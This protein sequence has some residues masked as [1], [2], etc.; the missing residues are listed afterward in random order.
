MTRP[1]ETARENG[2]KR[3]IRVLKQKSPLKSEV[4]VLGIL[5]Q[6][7]KQN[8]Q[9]GK[10]IMEKQ[11]KGH[12]HRGGRPSKL[13]K[14]LLETICEYLIQW[15]YLAEAIQKAGISR[16]S[17][18]RYMKIK[19]FARA[20]EEAQERYHEKAKE[21]FSDSNDYKSQKAE[22]QQEKGIFQERQHPEGVLRANKAD[23]IRKE[24][25][26]RLLQQVLSVYARLLGY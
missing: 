17:L 19:S 5:K 6:K 10:G 18:R 16:T 26:Y 13:T 2:V 14:I 20:I 11:F 4:G 15:L 25:A 8:S 24:P 9:I 21:R 7:T 22:R 12:G 1:E 23:E 3:G